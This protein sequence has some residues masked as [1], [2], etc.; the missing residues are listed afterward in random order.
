[1]TVFRTGATAYKFIKPKYIVATLFT[2]NETDE[3]KPLGDSY[4]IEDVIEDTT[5]IAQ[6]DN[7][8]TNIECETSDS[9]VKVIVK[10]GKWNINAEI[11]DTQSMLLK[12]LCGYTIDET[13]KRSY[14]PSTYKEMYIK[15]D[16]VFEDNEGNL[17]AYVVPRVQ[18]DSKMT[19][20]SLNSNL[21]RIALGGTAND[22]TFTVG[23]GASAKTILSPFYQDENYT[24]PTETTG[25]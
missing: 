23:E 2:G 3:D 5:S 11:G 8:K 15:F 18:L 21:G 13:R 12:A 6:D 14:A 4:I 20:E 22:T 7:E 10:N 16:V 24:L 17:V 1:M 9:P 25:S 19:I